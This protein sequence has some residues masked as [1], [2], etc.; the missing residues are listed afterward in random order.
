MNFSNQPSLLKKNQLKLKTI[1]LKIKYK[2]ITVPI[3]KTLIPI[4]IEQTQ[5]HIFKSKPQN[6]IVKRVSSSNSIQLSNNSLKKSI[7]KLNLI[8]NTNDENSNKNSA[9]NIISNRNMNLN[10]NS[11]S[12]VNT[13]NIRDKKYYL[14]NGYKIPTTSRLF[15][16]KRPKI[17]GLSFN[18]KGHRIINSHYNRELY[19]LNN[20]NNNNQTMNMNPKFAKSENLIQV[21]S[22]IGHNHNIIHYGNNSK[23]I[24]K[25][26]NNHTNKNNPSPNQ[27]NFFNLNFINI[28]KEEVKEYFNYENDKIIELTKDEKL[29]YGDRIKKIIPKVKLLGKGG[30]GIVWSCKKNDINI[31]NNNLN[32][33]IDEIAIK[34]TSKK[35]QN[36]INLENC[37]SLARNEIN[38]LKELNIEKNEIIPE[39]YDN[40][41]DNNDIWLFFEKCGLSLSNLSFK[42]KGEFYNNERIYYIQKGKFLKNIFENVTQF[43]LLTRKIIEGIDYM[44]NKGIIHSDIKPENILIELEDLNNN[45]SIKKIKIIDYGSSFNLNNITSITSNTPEYLCPEVTSNSKKFLSELSKN[46]KYIN[47]ID[48][49]SVGITLLELCLACPI[50]MN[51]KAKVIIN[52]KSKFTTGLFGYRGRDSNKIYNKQIELCKTLDKILKG[53]FIYCFNKDDKDNFIDLLE[54][55]LCFDYK[56]RIST[57]DALVHKFF[58]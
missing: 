44:N 36:G 24:N 50:W 18:S 56:N 20:L 34:Q 41:E 33:E 13:D 26:I 54:K 55:M 38:I 1:N 5:R 49:W 3:P 21:K 25:V 51:Y 35:I 12:R 32:D 22:K 46:N 58:S 45:F 39:I 6:R 2:K 10:S 7:R 23:G 11:Q 28:N 19:D 16:K 42:I 4:P 48:I 43:K 40:Y 15:Q 57:K 53:S 29:I 37:L 17:Q 8:L 14:M 27:N 30:C 9:S 31:I 47:S 52:G